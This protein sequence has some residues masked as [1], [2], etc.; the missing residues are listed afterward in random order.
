MPGE[1]TDIVS[2]VANGILRM[3]LSTPIS[4]HASVHHYLA[5]KMTLSGAGNSVHQAVLTMCQQRAV[6]GIRQMLVGN[7][8]DLLVHLEGT[9][10]GVA[11][12][13]YSTGRMPSSP[14][15]SA[16]PRQSRLTSLQNLQIWGRKIRF[17]NMNADAMR[18][19]VA[20]GGG[21]VELPAAIQPLLSL[22]ADK[23]PR[24]YE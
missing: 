7:F 2:P 14:I 18:K 9:L 23:C 11:S 16:G 20:R 13:G 21:L 19:L 8:T 3:T 10:I 22:Y 24:F 4:F 1:S 6:S 15:V 17:Q 5:D 12:L